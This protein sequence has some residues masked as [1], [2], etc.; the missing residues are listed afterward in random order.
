LPG[1]AGEPDERRPP[2]ARRLRSDH[3]ER[4]RRT[5]DAD[6]HRRRGGWRP[7]R[8]GRNPREAGARAARLSRPDDHRTRRWRHRGAAV[9]SGRA[10]AARRASER[11]SMTDTN[12]APTRILL[13]DDHALVRHG[14]RLI[15]DAEPDLRVVREA[16]DGAEAV[17]ATRDDDV[18][19]A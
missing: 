10:H 5:G 11:I 13:A 12:P 16:A 4:R 15:L 18:D 8:G 6:R 14:L 9:A 2:R 19:L 3:A 17:E 1:G 7:A